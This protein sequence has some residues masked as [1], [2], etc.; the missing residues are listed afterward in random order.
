[1]VQSIAQQPAE[2]PQTRLGQRSASNKGLAS[3]V[4]TSQQDPRIASRPGDSKIWLAEMK[5]FLLSIHVFCAF[6]LSASPSSTS[7]NKRHIPSNTQASRYISTK[8]VSSKLRERR[9]QRVSRRY[10]AGLG[11]LSASWKCR[12]G[13][14]PT[15]QRGSILNVHRQRQE[16]CTRV[17]KGC[18]KTAKV[19]T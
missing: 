1:M 17:K 19:K 6:F 4:A 15:R 3:G 7:L 13:D 8:F 18:P 16:T 2:P 11:K 14:L 9:R 5:I 12:D 10:T